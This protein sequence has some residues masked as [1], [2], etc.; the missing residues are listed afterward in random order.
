[1]T[2]I[3]RK[4]GKTYVITEEDQ[5]EILKLLVQ[6]GDL[7]L[8]TDQYMRRKYGEAFVPEPETKPDDHHPLR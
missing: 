8:A 4:N 1:M 5:R 2:I 6:C 3:A 7:E